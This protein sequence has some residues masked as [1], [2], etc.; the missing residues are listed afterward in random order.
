M[1]RIER[2][3]GGAMG[4][5]VPYAAPRRRRDP[6]RD[7]PGPAIGAAFASVPAGLLA[8]VAALFAGHGL[9]AALGLAA[10][11]QIAV[12]AAG[13]IWAILVVRT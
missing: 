2:L 9:L 10:L 11:A 3:D 1:P 7:A 4:R 12:F 8:L 13:M 5:A 6:P